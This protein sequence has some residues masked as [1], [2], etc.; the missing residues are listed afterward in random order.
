MSEERELLRDTV[1]A[2][3]GLAPLP[4]AAMDDDAIA[5]QVI[6]GVV[7]GRQSIVVRQAH[8]PRC[9]ARR[10]QARTHAA[11]FDQQNELPTRAACGRAQAAGEIVETRLGALDLFA[12]LIARATVKRSG[13]A[14]SGALGLLDLG[15]VDV[16]HHGDERARLRAARRA[17]AGGP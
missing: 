11:L 9:L 7:T 14:A 3:G 13:H 12:C 6:G 2:G 15:E 10:H 8:Q 5:R 1:A 16:A 17:A 4:L